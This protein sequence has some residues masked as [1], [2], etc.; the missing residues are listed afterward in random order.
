MRFKRWISIATIVVCLAGLLPCYASAAVLGGWEERSI[1]EGGSL[2]GVTYGNGLFVTVGEDGII[3]TSE[4]GE[5]WDTKDSTTEDY[6]RSVVYGNGKFVAVGDSGAIVTS[7][8]GETWNSRVFDD[9]V[10][11]FTSVAY[12]GG[13]YTAVADNGV[14]ISSHDGEEWTSQQLDHHHLYGIT[15]GADGQYVAVG[16]Q[17]GNAIAAMVDS[18][19]E[20]KTYQVE[21]GELY[22]VTYGNGM[23]VAAGAFPDGGK[24]YFAS[25]RDGVDWDSKPSSN[26]P[27][28]RPF[29]IAYGSGLFMAVGYETIWVSTDGTNW[30]EL[31]EVEAEGFRHVAYG[32]GSFVIVG[33]DGTILQFFLKYTV[34]YDGNGKSGGSV[35]VDNRTYEPGN[36]AVIQD[37]TGDLVKPGYTFGGWNTQK[38]GKGT[39]Y[40][41]GAEVKV[42][43]GDVTLYA[44]WISTNANL[45]GLTLSSGIELSPAFAPETT[46]Y[47]A[48]VPNGVS[49]ITVTPLPEDVNA[50]VTV[51]V[52]QNETQTGGPHV[53]T[54][55]AASPSLPLAVGNNTVQLTVTAQDGTTTKTYKVT[56]TRNAGTNS[57]ESPSTSTPNSPPDNPSSSTTQPKEFR[58][59]ING[60]EQERMGKSA[61]AEENGRHTFT[62][63][64]DAAKLASQLALENDKPL[65]TVIAIHKADKVTVGIAGDVVKSLA[66]KQAILDIRTPDGAIKLPAAEINMDRLARQLGTNVPI[67][68]V[69]I[70]FK[71]AKGNAAEIA[72]LDTASKQG[73]FNVV[74]GA[75]VNMTITA[76]APSHNGKTVAVNKFSTYTERE[77][78][79]PEGTGRSKVT[80]AVLLDAN[81]QVHH[82]PTRIVEHDGKQ[83]AVISSITNGTFALIGR[84]VVFADVAEHWAKNAVNDM[85]SRMVVNGI[86]DGRYH[87]DNAISRAEFAAIIVRAL[88]LGGIETG[89][90]V[91]FSDVL[92]TD[93]YA[94]VVVKAR[95]YGIVN[96]YEDGTFR[97]TQMITREEAAAMIMRAAKTAVLKTSPK[98]TNAEAILAG[99]PDGAAVG[100]WAREAFAAAVQ[101]G[102]FQGATGGLLP[103]QDIT[104]AETAVVVH[105][106]LKKAGL[107]D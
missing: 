96:G 48:N 54:N 84:S 25:S 7:T 92:S 37:N 101:N 67:A 100:T 83:V 81:G 51:S 98:S 9:G 23:Y 106:L 50:S 85:A 44:E 55:G 99:F 49:T 15:S 42:G 45:G 40:A 88:G 90:I 71:V 13:T 29:G 62:V 105:R 39:H 79:L 32:N 78:P 33:Y 86:D 5:H 59:L 38:D 70:H 47:T 63:T 11:D 57:P 6:L 36:D 72:R 58:I 12:S 24:G 87:P 91:S 3:M 18:N 27:R 56:V 97:P 22:G 77:I 82:V 89:E 20:W 28:V 34:T 68:D 31:P 21:Q 95:E 14:I 74:T 43:T 75:I 46:A 41:P 69:D 65:V 19:Q 52:Y 2:Y 102:I 103:K 35:P 10:D 17:G 104:R 64:V 66:N 8:D 73:N 61:T 94:G 53:L 60:I 93:W 107:I 30:T 26:K 1:P 16:R 76:S 4:N 80:T